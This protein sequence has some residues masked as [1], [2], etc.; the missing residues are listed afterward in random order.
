MSKRHTIILI[1]LTLFTC[2]ST[3]LALLYAQGYRYNISYSYP[4]SIYK[5]THDHMD[6]HRGELVL[7]CPPHNAAMQMALKRDYIKM[8]LC[9]SGLT[10]VIK[11]IMAME[12]NRISFEDQVV[13]INGQKMPS[14][15]V[16]SE[17]SQGRLLP[18][19]APFPLQPNH[20]PIDSFDSRYY[21]TVPFHH[22]LGHIEPVWVW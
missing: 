22:L 13:H 7:F 6:Y 20:S 11:K 9:P 4:T 18:Q 1:A 15:M 12:G 10:P 2:M 16:L 8:G 17:D 14:A 19:F 21:G 5:L 3:M